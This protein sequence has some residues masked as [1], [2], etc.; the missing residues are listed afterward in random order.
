MRTKLLPKLV[1]ERAKELGVTVVQCKFVAPD[2]LIA[3]CKVVLQ[4]RELR[5]TARVTNLELGVKGALGSIIIDGPDVDHPL[6]DKNRDKICQSISDAIHPYLGLISND[7][8]WKPGINRNALLNGFPIF[9]DAGLSLQLIGL[10]EWSGFEFGI[11]VS[12]INL[13]NDGPAIQ[14]MRVVAYEIGLW[15]EAPREGELQCA[16]NACSETTPELDR[17]LSRALDFLLD[18]LEPEFERKTNQFGLRGFES[19]VVT[20]DLVQIREREQRIDLKQ[21]PIK[22]KVL[23]SSELNP[24]TLI[25]RCELLR[26]GENTHRELDI[27]VQYSAAETAMRMAAYSAGTSRVAELNALEEQAVMELLEAL[28]N[29]LD[30]DSDEGGL[31]V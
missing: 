29:K 19:S 14:T 24:R 5:L 12:C 25:L 31:L 1:D 16:W 28:Q 2:S 15:E 21:P 27:Q 18:K 6:V 26:V 9:T 10:I 17:L 22:L 30:P 4:N 11:D 13:I 7:L 3:R 23:C 8:A 20:P